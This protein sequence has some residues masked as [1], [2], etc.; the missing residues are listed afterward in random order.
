MQCARCQARCWDTRL[1]AAEEEQS[2]GRGAA[3]TKETA[4]A[5]V[6]AG[7]DGCCSCSVGSADGGEGG[8]RAT[9]AWCGMGVRM[10]VE[11]RACECPERM[12]G[13]DAGERE[14]LSG[15]GLCGV[16]KDMARRKARVH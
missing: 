16:P 1:E 11:N 2:A 5:V 15:H 3:A 10:A 4:R 8:R 7:A 6:G 13:P 14:G 12:N 9:G